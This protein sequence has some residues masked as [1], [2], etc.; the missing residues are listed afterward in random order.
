[1]GLVDA[2]TDAGEVVTLSINW[3]GELLALPSSPMLASR[4]LARADVIEALDGFTD[5]H[6]ERFV[7][8]WYSADSQAALQAL[9]V[10]LKK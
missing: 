2:L 9:M 8:G 7:E 3:L 6:L 1:M 4:A 10:R 5:A